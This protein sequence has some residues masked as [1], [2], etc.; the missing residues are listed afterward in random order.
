VLEALAL[1][2]PQYRA[3]LRSDRLLE[4][5]AELGDSLAPYAAGVIGESVVRTAALAVAAE[6]AAVWAATCGRPLAEG[7]C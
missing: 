2:R 5:G 7:V 3:S 4:L 6:A 1:E